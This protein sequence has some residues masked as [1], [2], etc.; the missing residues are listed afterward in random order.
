MEEGTRPPLFFSL[1][2]G[3][4]SMGVSLESPDYDKDFL[5]VQENVY[6][7]ND[8]VGERYEGIDVVKSLMVTEYKGEYVQTLPT[9]ECKKLTSRANLGV[10]CPHCNTPVQSPIDQGFHSTVWVEAPTGCDAFFAPNFFPMIADLFTKDKFNAIEYLCNPRYKVQRPEASTYKRFRDLEIPRGYNAFIRNFD[11][12]VPKLIESKIFRQQPESYE[13]QLGVWQFACEN[14]NKIF[15]R[16]LPMPSKRSV[17]TEL[18]GRSKKMMEGFAQL[19][20]A[21]HSIH[22]LASRD[23]SQREVDSTIWTVH[24]LLDKYYTYVDKKVLS[25]KEGWYRKHIFGAR[26]GSS[27]RAVITSNAGIHDYEELWLPF[28]LGIALYRPLIMSKLLHRGYNV[29]DANAFVINAITAEGDQGQSEMMGI[30]NE[31]LD[32]CKLKGLPILL[33]RNPT[34]NLRSIQA[35]YCTRFKSDPADNTISLSVLVLAA[36]N[37]DFDGDQLQGYAILSYDDWKAASKFSPHSAL[38]DLSKPDD[39][40]N[41]FCIRDTTQS[42]INNFLSKRRREIR[43]NKSEHHR[44]R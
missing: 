10:I 6:L 43:G 1:N 5:G 16:F 2:Q 35:L 42:T 28:R 32:E 24:R 15:P 37:A 33:G 38:F 39:L 18:S 44:G 13:R 19:I 34:L 12:I 9:C 40:N 3:V 25:T 20:D 29:R 26:T 11:K 22:K 14:R 21:A 17:I 30:L 31:L 8:H 4:G 23:C 7:L 27:F 41:N 36:P